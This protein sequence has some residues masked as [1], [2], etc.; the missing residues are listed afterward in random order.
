MYRYDNLEK[1]IFIF[2]NQSICENKRIKKALI[3]KIIS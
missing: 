1:N 2:K 3:Y